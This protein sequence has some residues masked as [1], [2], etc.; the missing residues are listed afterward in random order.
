VFKSTDGGVTWAQ[1]PSTNPTDSRV[2]APP[3]YP[4]CPWTFINRLA[5]SPDGTTLLAATNNGCE[6]STDGGVTWAAK[7]LPNPIEDVDF[8]PTDSTKAV[9]GGLG[10][11]S[12]STNGGQ[13]W[14]PANFPPTP[15]ITGGAPG[16]SNNGRVELAYAPSNNLIVY[17][18]VDNHN[19]D[20]YRSVDG[21]QKYNIVNTGTNFFLSG[22]SLFGDQGWYDNALWVNPLNASFLIVGGIDLWRSTDAGS[23][24]QQISNWNYSPLSATLNPPA[25]PVGTSA[26]ADHHAIVA[27]R[28]FNNGSNQIVY[29][30]NDGGIYATLNVSTVQQ[31]SG[32]DDINGL[33]NNT[34]LY[35][36]VGNTSTGVIVAGAQD[37]STLK[38]SGEPTQWSPIFGG[39]GGVCAADPTTT[40]PKASIFYG[41]YSY[42]QIFRSKDG[43]ATASYIDGGLCDS[44]SRST[45][46]FVAPFVLDPNNA[47]T[48]LA[49]GLSLWRSTNV[50]AATPT[51]VRIKAPGTAGISAIAVAQGNPAF[52]VVGDN[53]GQVFLTQNGTAIPALAP[54]SG[55]ATPVPPPGP[56]TPTPTFTPAPTPNVPT[57]TNITKTLPARYVGRIVIDATKNPS[58]IYAGFGGFNANNLYRSTD[59]GQTWTTI[60]GS[61]S[62]ALPAVPIYSLTLNPLD[63]DIIYAGTEVGLFISEDA[64][65]TWELPQDGPANIAVEDLTWMGTDLLAA[66]HGRGLYRASGTPGLFVDCNAIGRFQDGSFTSPYKTITAAI[67]AASAGEEIWIAPC[68]YNEPALV[69]TA[70][71]V[72]SLPGG[73]VVINPSK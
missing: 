31:T 59:L 20:L 62:T 60:T 51:W 25:T 72:H 47:N 61:G 55:C 42:L 8:H 38:Y 64:G 40:D 6:R 5:I 68:T 24:F 71:Q 11:A 63:P 65:A 9:Y 35:G 13:D 2:C 18:V 10:S 23:T 67:N 39:D 45:A 41:E 46:G 57:W 14:S 50:T 29:F 21:G 32:W 3:P 49:G 33:L 19:G 66:T 48:M 73:P 15:G 4:N 69:N 43:G 27:A 36:A 30:G 37:N 54:A 7:G 17:A 56:G 28:G 58:W 22:S 26:H 1:L 70:V 44:G 34:Q 53:T 16:T 12:Y 52:I